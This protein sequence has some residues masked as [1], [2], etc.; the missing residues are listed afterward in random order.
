MRTETPQPIRL[1]EYRPPAF[2][3]D[4]VRLDFDLAPNATRVKARLSIRRNGEHADPLVLNGERLKPVSVAVDGKALDDSERTIDAEFLTVPNVPDAFVLET[5]VEIDPEA[6]KALDGLY[7]SGGRFCT[8]CEAEGFRKITWYPDRPDVLSRF[9]VRIEADTAFRHLLSN[10]NLMESGVLPNGRH[11]A[12]WNDPF[13]K[14]CYLF[15]LVAGELDVLEDKLVTMSG[16]TVDL[17]IFVDPG[18]APRA[19]YAMDALKRSMTWDE[20]AFGREYDLDLFMIVAVRD[21]NFGAM[22]NKGLNIFNSS[23]L[24]AEP[25][26]AT[27]M[28]YERIESVVAHEYFHNWTGDRITC[29]DWFQLCL[30]EGLTVFR[31]QSFSAD[32]R[33]AAVQRIKDVKAL[34][35]R[36]FPEDQGPL[37]HP[38]RP[39]TYL[40]IDNFYTATIYEKGAEVIRMLK[41]L[42]GAEAFRKGMDLYFNRWD[43]HATTVEEFIRCFAE[44]SGRDLSAFFAWYEQAGT[45]KLDLKHRYDADART[46]ELELS[47]ETAPT[48][49]QPDKHPLPTP[50]TVGLLDA[51]GRTLA[52]ERDGAALDETVIVL[53]GARTKVTLTG[54]DSAPVVSA[55][56][57][58]SAPVTLTT[59]AEPKDRYVQLAADPDL[60][61]RWEAGQDLA[62]ALIVARA[63]GAADEVGEERF[64][65]ALG[66]S[67]DDQAADPAFKALMLALPSESDLALALQPSDPAAIHEAR[68]ALRQRLS[69]HLGEDLKRL[70]IGLQELGEFSPDA[71]SAGR[72]ALR[73]AALDLLAANPR[74]EVAE[75]ADGHYR[76]AANMTDAI[77]GLSALMLIGGEAYEAALADFF[78]RWKS[79]PLV[80]DKWFALQARDP[81][82]GVLGRVLGLTAHPAFDEKNPNRLRALVS[83]FANFNPA[84]FHDPSGAGYR[85]L[86][87]Q[88]LAVDGFNPM[89]AARLVDPLGGWRRY[90]PE[91]GVLM[92]RELARIAGTEGLSKN[93]YELVSKA[94]AD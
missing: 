70:H 15:A 22:E 9:T 8:Q 33:G 93:V 65:H 60:F 13:P 59:D 18:M 77:G 71:A 25:A 44:V 32:M 72:R 89:T 5:E 38:V 34:R 56:R 84:R 82:E 76:A 4:E 79:E 80:V 28:D 51:E 50:V 64:A 11:F 26:T 16:R 87:D 29:R 86:A 83:T 45:P 7:M 27:D 41:T 54:V 94:L 31:D 69:V 10:G 37:A 21:F 53:E 78:E 2:L 14:P 20:E 81:D 91:L 88:I 92:K 57:G 43:G 42:I 1:S 66:R 74:S 30:K 12:V 52:F 23:L 48:P 35:A 73:N 58:F 3:I 61:N 39:S 55:L 40:K 68:E 63:T 36:Q 75:L 90:K 47:Q 17:R 62:R 19:A 46:L 49:G 24:L 67:L 85:F 6:N